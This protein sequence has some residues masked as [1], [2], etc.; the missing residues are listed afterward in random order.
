M[1]GWRGWGIFGDEEGGG[2][3]LDE[4]RVDE[5]G[6]VDAD[7]SGEVICCPMYSGLEV[8]IMSWQNLSLSPACM[9]RQPPRI[10]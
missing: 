1:G 4:C 10:G 8:T 3:E 2:V 7:L 5:V 9:P 6:M